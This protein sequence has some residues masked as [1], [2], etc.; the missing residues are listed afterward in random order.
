[1]SLVKTPEFMW[2]LIISLLYLVVPP[3]Y[4]TQQPARDTFTAAVYEHR[5]LNPRD[6]ETVVTKDEAIAWSYRNLRIY[7]EQAKIAARKVYYRYTTITIPLSP[8]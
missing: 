3:G 6:P 4:G 5:V 8:L 1:M 2:A 7:R